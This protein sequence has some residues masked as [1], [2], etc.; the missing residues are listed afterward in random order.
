[1]RKMSKSDI[2]RVTDCPIPTGEGNYHEGLDSLLGLISDN[3]PKLYRTHQV[4]DV[5][6]A[7]GWIDKEDVV[8]IKVNAQWK[9][10]GCTNSDMIRGLIQRILEHPDGFHGEIV[11]FENG[12]SGG[13]LDCDTM[14]GG[15]YPDAGVHANAE[16]ASHSF[17]YLVSADFLS[18]WVS[19]SMSSHINQVTSGVVWGQ[20]HPLRASEYP[21]RR[22]YLASGH[23]AL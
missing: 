13:S 23:T 2:Y 3:G 19:I 5:G 12:Q 1:M 15:Q 10:R 22:L 7:D 20:N 21:K 6:G 17:S 18:D 14:W 11:I 4:S 8:L 16:D 9:Y